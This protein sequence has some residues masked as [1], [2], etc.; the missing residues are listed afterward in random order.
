VEP[1]SPGVRTGWSAAL[2][3]VAVLAV[4]GWMTPSLL[5][6]ARAW[7]ADPHPRTPTESAPARTSAEPGVLAALVAELNRAR[8]TGRAAL[9]TAR[10]AGG[11]ATAAAR[12]AHAHEQAARRLA[13]LGPRVDRPLVR[14]L[15]DTG[16]AYRAIVSAARTERPVRFR[17]AADH[18][19]AADRALQRRLPARGRRAA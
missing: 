5:G 1:E 2:V 4:L 15:H 18:A 14:A 17:R 8:D 10:D 11:Q 7:N 9:R 12:L 6:G 3:A 13:A 19:A 16:A